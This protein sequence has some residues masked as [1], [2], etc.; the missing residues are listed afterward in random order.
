MFKYHFSTFPV[1]SGT[2]YEFTA[3]GV[4]I[5]LRYSCDGWTNELAREFVRHLN[6]RHLGRAS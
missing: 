5:G 2:G 1:I 3:Y 4:Q 6:A